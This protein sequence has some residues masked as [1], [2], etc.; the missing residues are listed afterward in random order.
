MKLAG[1]G[2]LVGQSILPPEHTASFSQG[3]R[4]KRQSVSGAANVHVTASQQL[5]DPLAA[6]KSHA[7]PACMMPSPQAARVVEVGGVV[8]VLVV[9]VMGVLVVV[10][11][12]VLVGPDDVVLVVAGWVVTVVVV[13]DVVDV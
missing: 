7:S 10:A 8:G 3:P 6:P 2:V 4:C 13:L 12:I 9:V 11:V 5:P 1:L